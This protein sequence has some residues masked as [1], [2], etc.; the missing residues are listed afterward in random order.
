MAYVK[1]NGGTFRPDPKHERKEKPKPGYIKRRSAKRTKQEK[2]YLQLNR[3]FL[4]DKQCQCKGCE[5]R[6]SEVH[7]KRGRIG[8]LL[9][10]IRFWLACCT[11]CHK[12][13]EAKPEW[14]KE[15]GYSLS[16]L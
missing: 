7:H 1:F 12:E 2:T 5:N 14:A 3:I 6:A 4:K 9:L 13:I 10:D 15:K 8:K 11:D 16:R